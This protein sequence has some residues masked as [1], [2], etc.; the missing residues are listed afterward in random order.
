MNK[1]ELMALGLDEAA[2]EEVLSE[3]EAIKTEYEK[4]IDS[5]RK[6]NE[7]ENLLNLSGARNKAVVRA[8]IDEEGDLKAQIE[9]LKTDRDTKF[10]FEGEKRFS[11]GRSAE[12]LPETEKGELEAR[13][14]AARE[15]KN[16]VEAI[17]IKQIAAKKGIMLL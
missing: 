6:E 9:K 15:G 1:D 2:A 10:L 4:K 16:T 17:R 12:K 14:K 3:R 11:P 13:L 7:I 8:L 5:L